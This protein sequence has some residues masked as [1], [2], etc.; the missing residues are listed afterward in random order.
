MPK[1]KKNSNKSPQPVKGP[2][3]SAGPLMREANARDAERRDAARPLRPYS[4]GELESIAGC[5]LIPLTAASALRAH[6]ALTQMIRLEDQRVGSRG[7]GSQDDHAR[8]VQHVSDI[9]TD[10][11]LDDELRVAAAQWL[12]QNVAYES[13][14]SEVTRHFFE[15]RTLILVE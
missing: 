3:L 12:E 8:A 13:G 9:A 14:C 5:K 4:C 1:T 7:R 15:I 11:D 10:P 6:E 2:W